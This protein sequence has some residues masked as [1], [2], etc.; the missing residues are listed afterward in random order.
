VVGRSCLLRNQQSANQAAAQILA[1]ASPSGMMNSSPHFPSE[2]YTTLVEK[3]MGP[4]ANSED[5]IT[6]NPTNTPKKFWVDRILGLFC[7]KSSI[8]NEGVNTQVRE[9]PEVR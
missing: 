7:A 4:K 8:N 6:Y 2:S 9:T 1:S 3:D 5:M